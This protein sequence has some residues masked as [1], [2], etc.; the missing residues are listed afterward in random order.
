MQDNYRLKHLTLGTRRKFTKINYSLKK[1]EKI[2][3]M[4]VLSSKWLENLMEIPLIT[5]F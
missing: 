3:Q 5:P 2:N 1:K 4:R